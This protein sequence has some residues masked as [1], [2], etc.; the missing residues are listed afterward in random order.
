[1][2]T[3][4]REAITGGRAVNSPVAFAS[5]TVLVILGIGGFFVAGNHHAVGADGGELLGFLRV[6]ML[7]NGVHLATGAALIA[8]AIL[9]SRQARLTNTVVGVG[10]LL[11]CL[12]G[13]TVVGT[14][15][16]LLALNGADNALHLALGLAQTAVG[17]SADRTPH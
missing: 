3:Y 2:V 12:V 9:G 7:H 5:G 11:L 4:M 6:N 14:T 15:A 13:L 8:A 1:M 17:L 16:N 10:Y